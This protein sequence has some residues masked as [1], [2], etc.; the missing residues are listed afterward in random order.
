MKPRR[1]TKRLAAAV[2][3]LAIAAPAAFAATTS[4]HQTIVHT[5]L[6]KSGVVVVTGYD[7]GAPLQP[8]R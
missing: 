5:Q 3:V 6:L 2:A 4:S 8:S 1:I 7:G